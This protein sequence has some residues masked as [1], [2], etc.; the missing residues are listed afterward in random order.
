[1]ISSPAPGTSKPSFCS[2]G[3]KFLPVALALITLAYLVQGA[4]VGMTDDEAYY[5]VLSQRPALGYAYHPPMVAWL[6]TLT[7]FLLGWAL[8]VGS[9]L[10][11]RIPAIACMIAFLALC[12]RWLRVAGLSREKDGLALACLLSF[13][14]MFALAWMMVPDLPLLLGWSLAY[15]GTWELSLQKRWWRSGLTIALGVAIA[16]L[17]KF[18]GVAIALS[19]VLSLM[20]LSDA[21]VR[22]RLR[23]C[24]W[25]LGGLALAVIPILVWNSQHEWG[26]LLYQFHDRHTGASANW[27]RYARFWLVQVAVAG[28]PLVAFTLKLLFN[29]PGVLRAARREPSAE[30]RILAYAWLWA[31]PA[32]LVF[33]VQPLFSDFKIHWAYV[34]W[35]PGLLAFAWMAARDQIGRGARR[36]QL[37]Y[38]FALITLVWVACQLPVC[39]W[40]IRAFKGESFDVKLDV[41]NDLYGWSE[42]REWLKPYRTGVDA[43]T[44]VIGSWYQTASQ[45]AFALGNSELV[46]LVPRDL[47]S[48]DEWPVLTEVSSPGPDWPTLSAP[49]FYV[50]DNRYQDPPAFKGAKCSVV[51]MLTARRFGIT[52]KRIDLWRCQP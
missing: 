32:A 37:G 14:G 26:S 40:S 33:C 3:S 18:S 27:I 8:P 43:G 50:N 30:S 4:W 12:L 17:S 20:L 36:F 1:M 19:S 5:W 10:L 42:F 21:P 24:I 11:V 6:I 51:G 45:A 44:P 48:L 29:G 35:W 25:P 22:A 52:V 28:A 31:A 23:S 41:T 34:V 38:G 13:G 39:S 15:L 47:K 49:V 9:G 16:I 2:S 7:R 46:S